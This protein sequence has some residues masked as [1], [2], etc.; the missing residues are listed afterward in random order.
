MLRT[1]WK[2]KN[3]QCLLF[4][5]LF[6]FCIFTCLA[7]SITQFLAAFFFGNDFKRQLQFH[8]GLSYSPLKYFEKMLRD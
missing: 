6:I 2:G 1:S 5:E 7:L 4:C 8:V 3:I